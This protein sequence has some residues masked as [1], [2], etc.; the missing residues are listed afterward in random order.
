VP[1]ERP[2]AIGGRRIGSGQPPYLIAEVGVNHDGSPDQ[3]LRLVEAAAAAGADAVKFQTFTAQLLA[4]PGAQQAAYQ[5]ERAASGSQQEMLRGLELPAAALRACRQRADDLGITFLSTPFDLPSVEL[6]AQIGVPAFKVGSGDLTNLVLLRAIARHGL[7]MLVSTGMASLA[8]VEAA[9]GDIRAHGDPPL[10]LLHCTSAYPAASR[11]AN[12]RAMD[13]LRDR[14]EVPVGYSDHTLGIVVA[15]AAAAV[16][17]AVIEKH[18]TLDRSRPGPDHAASLEPAQMAELVAAVGEA[19]EAQGDG[20]KAPRPDEEDAAGAS[21]RSLVVV[22]PLAAGEVLA[23]AD[24]DAMRPAGG[25]SPL[26][27]DEVVGRRAS[28]DLPPRQVLQP[29]DVDPALDR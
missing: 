24:L 26:R 1:A 23:E 28:R 13:T 6:L 3:A 17:A 11:D 2:F 29:S 20:H 8:E 22:R 21:R 15:L 9:V 19:Y 4:T 7:P 27:L 5:R 16:G 25:I 10:A 12:L 14:F 18:L